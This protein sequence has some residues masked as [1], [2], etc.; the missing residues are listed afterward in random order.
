MVWPRIGA[1]ST[2][3]VVARH[4]PRATAASWQKA[5]LDVVRWSLQVTGAVIG[6]RLGTSI[7]SPNVTAKLIV[8][9]SGRADQ[10]YQA[11]IVSLS[12]LS[13]TVRT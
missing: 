2:D 4:Q 7:R 13:P 5:V 10:G 8:I 12:V 3:L 1:P 6:H 9:G 11:H